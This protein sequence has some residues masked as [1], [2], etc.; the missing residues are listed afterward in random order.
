MGSGQHL[1]KA[2]KLIEEQ[3]YKYSTETFI[4][5]FVRGWF[6]EQTGLYKPSDPIHQD[7]TF[8]TACA[9]LSHEVASLMNAGINFSPLSILLSEFHTSAV[10]NNAYYPTSDCVT[11]LMNLL[12]NM[13]DSKGKRI[14]EPCVGPSGM[15]LDSIQQRFLENQDQLNPLDGLEIIVEDIDEVAL[16][17][18]TLHILFLISYLNESHPYGEVRPD[19]IEIKQINVL[20]RQQ[21]CFFIELN[22]PEYEEKQLSKPSTSLDQFLMAG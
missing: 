13:G 14:Y 22:S 2:R 12:L 21:G 7:S 4:T 1:N 15:I 3:R 8:L 10:K 9:M 5:E 19:R 11:Q 6:F 17:A 18:F 16:K 20:T